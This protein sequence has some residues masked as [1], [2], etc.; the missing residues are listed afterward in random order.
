MKM[1]FHKFLSGIRKCIFMNK[2]TL[3]A[4]SVKFFWGF[5]VVMLLGLIIPTPKSGQS[6]E[7][8]PPKN[9]D[10]KQDRINT[11]NMVYDSYCKKTWVVDGRFL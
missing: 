8:N 11:H 2:R 3:N 10:E 4:C 7:D 9:P 6:V 1:I 5:T